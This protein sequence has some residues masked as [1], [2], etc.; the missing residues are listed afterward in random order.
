[1]GG[2]ELA[3]FIVAEMVEWIGEEEAELVEG[4]NSSM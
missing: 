4:K 3:A 1:M 2:A